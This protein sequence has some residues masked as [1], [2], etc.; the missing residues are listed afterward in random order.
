MFKD[1]NVRTMGPARYYT[2]KCHGRTM[3]SIGGK[4]Q[5]IIA[6]HVGRITLVY[7]MALVTS[8]VMN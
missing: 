4:S 2:R 5:P 3:G 6:H 1:A 7:S 8:N